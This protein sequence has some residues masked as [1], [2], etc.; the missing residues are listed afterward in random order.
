MTTEFCRSCG[1]CGFPMKQTEDYAGSDL[2]S[3]FC[4][5]CAD[6]NGRLKPF[7]QVVEANANYFVREQGIDVKAAREMARALL[8]SMPAWKG[9]S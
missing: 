1:S 3:E 8:L 6:A 7:N 2:N 4:S 5:T 9:Q